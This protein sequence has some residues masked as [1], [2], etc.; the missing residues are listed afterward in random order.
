MFKLIKDNKFYL[1]FVL[2]FWLIT[3]PIVFWQRN[4]L[5]SWYALAVSSLEYSPDT[6]ESFI[7]AGDDALEDSITLE[8]LEQQCQNKKDSENGLS[9]SQTIHLNLMASICKKFSSL[10]KNRPPFENSLWSEKQ[11]QWSHQQINHPMQIG[12]ALPPT[13]IPKKYW[14]DHINGV[15]EALDYYK[16]ALNYSGPNFKAVAR[17]E[18][19]AGAACRDQD[20][21]LAYTGHIYHT[22]NY[23]LSQLAD[24]EQIP[25][26]L[27]TLQKTMLLWSAIKEDKEL[28]KEFN[29]SHYLV[30]IQNLL[31]NTNFSKSSPYEAN[32]LYLRLILFSQ[33]NEKLVND[34]RF[35]WG[36]HLLRIGSLN[37]IFYR[38]GIKRLHYS[39]QFS[40]DYLASMDLFS[41]KLLRNRKFE[42]YLLTTGAYLK[43][44]QKQAAFQEFKKAQAILQNVDG[45]MAEIAD[46]SL[47]KQYENVEIELKIKLKKLQDE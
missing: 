39:I 32:K 20:T 13:I 45:R 43:L 24:K 37:P 33:P 2:I 12:I 35:K 6:M 30:S 28:Q 27:S 34:H 46:R 40:P 26:H 42:V 23:V 38:E 14:R 29:A 47:L 8:S 25:S 10:N 9:C 31:K 41:Q 44:K 36:Q 1:I 7:R 3:F 11:K 15:L 21:F 16:R 5:Y 19:A 4:T 18:K 22:E 17:V